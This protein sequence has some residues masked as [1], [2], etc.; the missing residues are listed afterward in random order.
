MAGVEEQGARRGAV[1]EVGHRDLGDRDRDAPVARTDRGRRDVTA[2]D[3][4]ELAALADDFAK[5][6]PPGKR[7]AVGSIDG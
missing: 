6:L 2:A 7:K 1:G 3:E 5:M 4:R